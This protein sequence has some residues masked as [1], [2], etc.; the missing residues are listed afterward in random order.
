MATLRLALATTIAVALGAPAANAGLVSGITGTVLP[1]CGPTSTPFSQFGDPRSYYAVPD[2]G[3]EGGASGWT[4]SGATVV[5]GNEPW[6]VSGRGRSALALPPGASAL[7]PAA[8]INLLAPSI[9][10]FAE[11]Q[12]PNGS[13]R[14]EVLFRGITGNLLGVLNTGDLEPGDYTSWRPTTSVPSLLAVP[15]ATTSFQVRFTSK[16]SR[17]TWLIDDLYVDPWANRVG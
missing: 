10:L 12:R 4:L 9:R 16:A 13:L 15:L 1:S 6:F 5:A 11:G 14:V 3:L 8:C 7:S 2:N 17:G